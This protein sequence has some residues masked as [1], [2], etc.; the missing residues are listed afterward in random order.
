MRPARVLLGAIS[1]LALLVGSVATAGQ[2]GASH[3]HVSVLADGLS[4]PKGIDV[5]PEGDPVVGQGA[6]G[7]PGP[8]VVIP[9]HGPER[10]EVIALTDPFNLIDI[11]ISPLDGTGWGIGPGEVEGEEHVFL[12]HEL[13]DGTIVA[14]L[15]ITLYQ[16]GDPDLYDQDDFPEESNPYGL[17]IMP[18]GDALIADAANNDIVRVTP[19]GDAW[20]VARFDLRVVSTSHLPPDFEL[21]PGVPVPPEM[22]AEAVPTTVTIGP[23][24]AIYVGQLMGFP[25]RPGTSNIWRIEPDAMDALCSTTTPDPDCSVH[26][27]GFTGIQDIDFNLNNGKLYVYELAAEGVLAFEAGLETGEFPPAVLLLVSP[28]GKQRELVAGELSQPGGVAVAHNGKVFVTDGVFTEGRV[29]R[30]HGV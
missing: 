22:T 28:N 12:Y 3:S 24:G 30:I 15:D 1:P 5:S 14:V 29:I 8:V 18:N 20:T 13:S 11:A 7:P 10:G 26:L 6:F 2:V 19:E 4:S 25:F 23:D 21:E 27:T 16:V 17:T 9:L